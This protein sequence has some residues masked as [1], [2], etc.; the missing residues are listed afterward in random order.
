MLVYLCF[1]HQLPGKFLQGKLIALVHVWNTVRNRNPEAIHLQGCVNCEITQ[2]VFQIF[3]KYIIMLQSASTQHCNWFLKADQ[4]ILRA[5]IAKKVLYEETSL[6]YWSI[7]NGNCK[8]ITLRQIGE[9]KHANAICQMTTVN[10]N[11]EKKGNQAWAFN[12]WSTGIFFR[13]LEDHH[14]IYV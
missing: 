1:L 3:S 7:S 4:A 5:A 8:R 10:Q 13:S 9:F 11:G 12:C 14:C 6:L 2:M